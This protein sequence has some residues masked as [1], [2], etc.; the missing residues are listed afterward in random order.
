MN[1]LCWPCLGRYSFGSQGLF[2][3][4]PT[5]GDSSSYMALPTLNPTRPP[6]AAPGGKLRASKRNEDRA[7]VVQNLCKT[8]TATA[9][10]MLYA[11]AAMTEMQLE[12]DSD[13]GSSID[14]ALASSSRSHLIEQMASALTGSVEK[15]I[16]SPDLAMRSA[17]L[18]DLRAR[19][20]PKTLPTC[21]EFGCQAEVDPPVKQQR[22]SKAERLAND[23][24]TAI[25]VPPSPPR[26]ASAG[27]VK[28]KPRP[29]SAWRSA[30]APPP[31]EQTGGEGSA[32]Y[33]RLKLWEARRE[34][35]L[36]VVRQKAH[37]KA[38]ATFTRNQPVSKLY[39]HVESAI[40][41]E[42]VALEDSRV[43]EAETRWAR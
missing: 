8:Y 12:T 43:N 35:R 4:A 14:A 28:A 6:P 2:N 1:G 16:R 15:I 9:N 30:I 22:L 11:F 40:K 18:R 42:R 34:E 7:Q 25:P 26:A 39:A 41:R 3:R 17:V 36:E 32:M 19:F 31:G 38:H 29:G 20:A 37:D 5:C 23:I 21:A 13:K 24:A 10:K 27:S 33:D